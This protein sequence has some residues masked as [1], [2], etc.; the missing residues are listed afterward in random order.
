MK[1][2]LFT[3]ATV[4]LITGGGYTQE[5]DNAYKA[6]SLYTPVG[7]ISFGA[8]G[9]STFEIGHENTSSKVSTDITT[10]DFSK[11]TTATMIEQSQSL[12]T[13]TLAAAEKAG[14]ASTLSSMGVA[15]GDTSDS[16]NYANL[17]PDWAYGCRV[18]FWIIG[19]TPDEHFGFDFNLDADARCLFVRAKDNT[20]DNN[21]SA[22][23][24][25]NE[26][27][28]YAVAI[29]DQAKIWG[30][31]DA[32]PAFLTT[33]V[34]FGRMKE[35][36]LRGSIGDFGQRESSDVKSEDDIF[37]EIWTATGLFASAK[38]QKDTVLD[39]LIVQGAVDFTGA[40]DEDL[41]LPLYTAMRTFQGGVGYTIP[42]IAQIKAQFV[43]DTI[44]ESNY[45][46][47]ASKFKSARD[48]GFGANDYYGKM[49]FGIDYLGFMGG[50]KG[51]SD[52]DL[53]ANPNASLIELGVKVPIMGDNDLRAYDP[54]TFYNWYTCLGTIGVIQK[55]FIMYKGHIWGGQGESNLENYTDIGTGSG[56][57]N[58]ED[59]ANIIMAGIDALAEVCAN[60][61]GKQDV[62]IGLSANYNITMADGDGYA[63]S[64]AL[65]LDDVSLKQHKIG[66]ELYVKKTFG[67]NNYFF[68]GVADRVTIAQM[69]GT[70]DVSDNI[71]STYASQGLTSL[72]ASGAGA[73]VDLSYKSFENKVYMPIGIEMF[74]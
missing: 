49:E 74:F 47:A 19:R 10:S 39:G 72:G 26:D 28:K 54:E 51:L 35:Q 23:T 66:A 2:F 59:P 14:I 62:F 37:T 20:T 68:I 33:K 25:Y 18:G 4:A 56:L 69:D 73:K 48:A 21:D 24:N 7:N 13:G 46:Y 65:K 31:F 5:S 67:A 53:D 52:V 9:R 38:G 12:P 6:T 11:S 8:W 44:A 15:D 57:L 22:T 3:I 63:N 41:D 70:L 45:K 1:K 29:G 32:N 36:D 43:G 17:N 64:K 27:G 42:G 40:G 71:T 50:A 34:A 55:G 60:P 30:V 61:F 16:R 58:L